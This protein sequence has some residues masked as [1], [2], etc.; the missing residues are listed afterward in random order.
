MPGPLLFAAAAA[1]AAAAVFKAADGSGPDHWSVC[2]CTALSSAVHSIYIYIYI[3]YNTI[4]YIQYTT[5]YNIQ[6]Y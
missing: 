3:I 1:A 5:I 2:C 4:A 6:I